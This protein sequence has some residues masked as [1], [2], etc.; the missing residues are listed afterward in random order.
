MSLKNE[1]HDTASFTQIKYMCQFC[2]KTSI[3]KKLCCCKGEEPLYSIT[4]SSLKGL[5]II[6]S[7]N[8]T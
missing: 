3:Q 4:S 8:Y 6:V 1:T 7:S 5:F 2:K